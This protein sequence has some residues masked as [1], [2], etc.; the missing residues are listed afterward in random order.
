MIKILKVTR[1]KRQTAYKGTVNKT[2][3]SKRLED[4]EIISS[5]GRRKIRFNS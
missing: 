4:S 2:D 5:I 1:K 3:S